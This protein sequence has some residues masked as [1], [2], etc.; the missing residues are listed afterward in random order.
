MFREMKGSFIGWEIA[1]IIAIATVVTATLIAGF[2]IYKAFKDNIAIVI[3]CTVICGGVLYSLLSQLIKAIFYHG[4]KYI[5]YGIY[6][7]WL[8]FTINLCII[9]SGFIVGKIVKKLRKSNI[10]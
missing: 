10:K 8:M 9:L 7:V 3:L 2:G 6:G 4:G 1:L 5:N